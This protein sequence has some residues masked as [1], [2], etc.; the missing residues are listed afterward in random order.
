V[1]KVHKRE[2]V[3]LV[4]EEKIIDETKN[5]LSNHWSCSQYIVLPYW[6]IHIGV[7]T[8]EIGYIQFSIIL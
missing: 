3:Q 7:Q 2:I 6:K 8:S 1:G 4:R 5:L